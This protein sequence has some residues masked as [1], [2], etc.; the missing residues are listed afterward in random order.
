MKKLDKSKVCIIAVVV[1]LIIVAVICRCT[2]IINNSEYYSDKSIFGF[3]RTAIYLGLFAAWGISVKNR[4]IQPQVR[5][6]FVIIAYLIFFWLLIRGIKYN[7]VVIMLYPHIIRAI[8][9]LYYLPMLFIPLMILFIAL[10]L[11]KPENYRLPKKTLLLYIP[12]IILLG[13]VLTN[14]LHQLVF[15]F[16][17][18]SVWTDK[19]YSYGFAYWPVVCWELLCSFA[20]L[21]VMMIKC[22][23]P[24]S[25]RTMWLPFLPLS[26]IFIYTVMYILDIYW[27]WF[28]A[29]DMTVTFCVL[30]AATL[31][32]CIQCGLIQSNSHYDELLKKCTLSIQLTDADYNVLLKSLAAKPISALEMRQTEAEPFILADGY[33]LSGSAINGGHVLWLEDVS[34]LLAVLDDLKEIQEEL[35]GANAI[36]AA[37]YAL[38]VRKTHIEEQ[39][40]LFDVIQQETLGQID[41]LARLIEEFESSETESQRLSLLGKMAV[42]GAYL[43]RRNN[44]IFLADKKTM[45]N[46]RE[47]KLTF[48][49]SMDNLELCGVECGFVNKLEDTVETVAVAAMYDFFEMIVERSL[50]V[51]SALTVAIDS[52]ENGLIITVNTDSSAD[53]SDILTDNVNAVRDDDGE[54]QLT[55]CLNGEVK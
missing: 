42:I 17:E 45:I 7:L 25:R 19:E 54:W 10:M 34:K 50:G 15:D 18:N 13:L 16:P 37:E 27:V 36:L 48:G 31:E 6:F 53:F 4:I 14:D 1:A 41:L 3:L 28:I 5:R 22:R 23:V 47:L 43:K 29:G 52:R 12:T 32:C 33:R 11:G 55:M 44:L 40:R 2:Y 8:W 21:V 51:M 20:A 24:Y 9:Y 39:D 26:A 30:I 35:E 49:E 46:V 38:K